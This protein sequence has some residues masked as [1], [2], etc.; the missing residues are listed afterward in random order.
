MCLTQGYTE[1]FWESASFTIRST[2][3][4]VLVPLVQNSPWTWCYHYHA[5]TAGIIF[6]GLKALSFHLSSEKLLQL[7][8]SELKS[9][10][11][12]I[13][14]CLLYTHSHHTA[15]SFYLSVSATQQPINLLKRCGQLI[16]E[17]T[18]HLDTE[19]ITCD[20]ES[21][22][23]SFCSHLTKLSTPQEGESFSHSSLQY[24]FSSIV[25][26][27]DLLMHSSLKFLPHYFSQVEV[28]TGYLHHLHSF[29]FHRCVVAG[30]LGI[31]VLLHD[32]ISALG[33]VASHLTIIYIFIERS[34]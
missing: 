4:C 19:L 9:F 32:L 10:F 11:S 14:T 15:N 22:H 13:E 20:R 3:F 21:V 12:I 33:H 29:P 26:C 23:R 25:H 2:L 6:L 1:E 31:L 24:H 18:N 16:S 8:S 34:S 27:W 17:Q 7:F 30:V 5:P 28:S